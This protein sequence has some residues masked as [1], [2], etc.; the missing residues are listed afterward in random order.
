MAAL[1]HCCR[2]V[3]KRFQRAAEARGQRPCRD[4]LEVRQAMPLDPLEEFGVAASDFR[5]CLGAPVMLH[6]PH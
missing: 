2:A 4:L 3:P 1:L 6:C 5:Y